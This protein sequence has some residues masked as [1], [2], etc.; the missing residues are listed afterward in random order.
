MIPLRR[1]DGSVR[2]HA[3][4][5]REDAHLAAY[6]WCLMPLGYV[7][8][9]LPRPAE[10]CIY[11][12]RAVLGLEPGDGLQ[13]DHITGDRLDNRRSNLRI[14]TNAQN[15][16]NLSS[17]GGTSRYRGVYWFADRGKWVAAVT[18]NGRRKTVGYFDS[19][20]DAAHAAS[21]YRRLHMPFSVEHR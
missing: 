19:E 9:N 20:D 10:G 5:D 16:Q 11:L 6:R 15:S 4:I 8:R 1:R 17:K 18:L 21:E 3:K 2:A 14:V 13:A 7:V 12:H